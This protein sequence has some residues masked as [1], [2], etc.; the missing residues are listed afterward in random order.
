L[1]ITSFFTPFRFNS[2]NISAVEIPEL[3][4]FLKI[5]IMAANEFKRRLKSYSFKKKMI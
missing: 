3:L 5:V 1:I 4:K 2:R